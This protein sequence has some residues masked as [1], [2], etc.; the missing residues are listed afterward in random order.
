MIRLL[1]L[2]LTLIST[3]TATLFA[4]ALAPADSTSLEP[5]LTGWDGIQPGVTTP[6]DAVARLDAHEWVSGVYPSLT[7]I[8]VTWNGTQPALFDASRPTLQGRL[9]VTDGFITSFAVPTT[10]TFGDFRLALG[11][12]DRLTIMRPNREGRPS[13]LIV[14][15]SYSAR[16]LHLFSFID[17]P[18]D[19]AALWRAPVTASWGEPAL[20]FTPINA[21]ESADRP[22]WFFRDGAPGC[23]G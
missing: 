7:H 3:T 10:A 15:A 4:L 6:A 21:G 12:P 16:D 2:I 13:G 14:M 5:L 9:T 17:C 1:A 11:D 22:A 8:D 18:A 20:P 19:P 23:A